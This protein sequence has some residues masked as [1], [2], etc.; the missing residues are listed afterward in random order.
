MVYSIGCTLARLFRAV[1]A[2]SGNN[3][4][5]CSGGNDPIAFTA[6]TA[7]TTRYSPISDARDMRD[8][9]VKNN[10]CTPVMDKASM[11]PA[12][13]SGT[14]VKT[15]YKGCK[16]GYPVTWIEFDGSHTPQPK[17]RGANKTFSAAETWAF[18]SQFKSGA[19]VL[20]VSPQ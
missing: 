10:G 3:A 12:K 17:D 9:F 18:F 14:H 4:F 11:S 1:A 13:G 15:V 7:S 2:Q 6:S 20:S 19:T 8:R 5:A 16:E